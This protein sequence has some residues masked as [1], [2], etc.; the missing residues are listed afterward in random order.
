MVVVKKKK[1]ESED[2]L[3]VRFRNAVQKAGIIEE[4]KE[5]SH[6]TTDADKRKKQK[7]LKKFN[8]RKNKRRD[9]R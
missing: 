1:G 4:A 8:I 6:H 5:R 9:N 3:I 7:E 2:D